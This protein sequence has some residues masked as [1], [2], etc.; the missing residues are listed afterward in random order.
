MFYFLENRRVT[1]NF[2]DSNG[3]KITPPTGFTQGK[4]TVIDND[5]YTFTQSGTLP[6]TYTSGGKTYQLK[7]WYKG[8]TPSTTLDT[9]KPTYKV[10]YDDN[11]DLTV[12]YEEKAQITTVPTITYKFGFI[13]EKG[14][15]VAPTNFAMTTNLTE[16]SNATAMN[17]GTAT[18]TNVGNLKQLTIP[19]RQLTYTKDTNPSFYGATDF[20]L[21]IPKYYQTPTVTPGTHYSGSTTAYPIA[22]TKLKYMSSTTEDRVQTDGQAYRLYTTNTANSYSIYR[23]SWSDDTTGTIFSDALTRFTTQ[24]SPAYYTTDDT[25]FYFLENRRV[26]EN[27]VDSNGTKITPPTDFTQGKQTVIDSDNFTYTQEG[28]LPYIY[29]INNKP[30]ILKGWYKGKNKPEKLNQ[31]TKDK[32]TI[33]YPVSYDDQDDVTVVYDELKLG[34]NTIQFGFVNEQGNYIAPNNFQIKTD[35]GKMINQTPYVKE[36]TVSSIVNGNYLQLIIPSYAPADG[37]EIGSGSYGSKNSIVTAPRYYK[38]PTVTPPNTYTGT[39]YP[40]ATG[41][42]KTYSDDLAFAYEPSRLDLTPVTG[43]QTDYKIMEV[44]WTDDESKTT[45]SSLYKMNYDSASTNT[46]KLFEVYPTSLVNYYVEN[47]RVTENFVD[48]TGAKI[49]PPTGFTQGK[50]TVIDSDPYTFTQSGTLPATYTADGKTYKL[51]GWYKGKDKPTTLRT[52]TP[53]YEVTY[54]DNDDLTVVYDEQTSITLPGATYQF[55]FIDDSGKIVDPSKVGL[56]YDLWLLDKKVSTVT[57]K[58]LSGVNIGNVKSMSIPDKEIPSPVFEDGNSLFSPIN[59]T[60]SL[61]K[62]YSSMTINNGLN[63]SYLIPVVTEHRSN[64]A[65]K[66]FPT[67]DASFALQKVADQAYTTAYTNSNSSAPNIK[68]PILYRR[69]AV[70]PIGVD[71]YTNYSTFSGPV[72][73]TLNQRRITESFVD[74]TGEKITPPTGFTQGN[75]VLIT[76]NDFTYTSAKALPASYTADGKTYQLKGWY[77]GK[78]KPATLSTG[79]PTYKVTYDD[80]DDLTVVYDEAKV[81]LPGY[82]YQFGFVDEAGQLI[83]PE[84]VNMTYDMWF[85]EDKIEK[86]LEKSVKATNSGDLKEMKIADKV[87]KEPTVETLGED[88]IYSPINI[89]FTLPKYY[90]TI[91]ASEGSDTNYPLPQM[92]QN[93][94]GRESAVVATK[95]TFALKKLTDQTFGMKTLYTNSL[96]PNTPYPIPF[97]RYTKWAGGTSSC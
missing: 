44:S 51:K 34:G 86:I 49:T 20:R 41:V 47:R 8:K 33:S 54:D 64:E 25:M 63:S 71:P 73:Y 13:N 60:F 82:T 85:F 75:Q 40:V 72:Y 26:T 24:A 67:T 96:V 17:V 30:Y 27:F 62:Y 32:R 89:Q 42:Y 36:Q 3:T 16:V 97:R 11:D 61:P 22:T 10:T 35:V 92:I 69:Y 9:G 23:R 57:N 59:M 18:G 4:K 52:D 48:A 93:S 1:E 76:N 29:K 77:K 79:T 45:F 95:D 15:Y 74:T 53:T 6:D 91:V 56:T 38:T 58:N 80:N 87:V 12:V 39:P 70:P 88:T 14:E 2:V 68:F 78:D 81:T 19:G 37:I 65:P 90:E 7:G 94:S 46:I 83:N 50:Q 66:E 31:I 5:S 21:A 55:G 43:S 28:T 84:L